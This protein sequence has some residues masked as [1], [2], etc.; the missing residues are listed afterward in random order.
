MMR[1]FAVSCTRW[2]SSSSVGR[3]AQCRSS[4]T[5]STGTDAAVVRSHPVTASNSRARSDSGSVRM[6]CRRPG[7]RSASSGTRRASSPANGAEPRGRRTSSASSS[8]NRSASTN[9]WYG[10]PELLVAAAGEHERALVARDQRDLGG[11]ARLAD[12]GLAR[13]RARRAATLSP[14]PSTPSTSRSSSRLRP[15]ESERRRRRQHR[16]QR[17]LDRAIAT[18]TTGSQRT[19]T[20][21]TGPGM[22][23][24]SRSPHLELVAAAAAGEVAHDLGAQDLAALGRGLEPLRLDHREAE[25][26][27]ALEGDVA[28]AD[29]DPHLDALGLAPPVVDV[30]GLLDRDRRGHRVDRG[31]ERGHHAVAGVLHDRCR[32]C[33]SMASRTNMSCVAAQAR[34]PPPRRCGPVATVDPTTSVNS[35]VAVSTRLAAP[36]IPGE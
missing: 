30:D 4:S 35:T 11:E 29:A 2:R 20:A 13:E 23:L 34:R 7:T 15:D 25:A 1:S 22:P 31:R 3:S 32:G 5:S 26:V 24:S 21:G 8:W 6:R 17:R 19:S 36:V 9:G 33:V 14:L 10:E 27:V 16:W 28:D 12:P 18:W